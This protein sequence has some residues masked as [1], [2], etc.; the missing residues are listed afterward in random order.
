MIKRLNQYITHADNPRYN[1]ILTIIFF[2]VFS[3]NI[4]RNM[5]LGVFRLK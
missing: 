5:V 2:S 4:D 1:R 3:L